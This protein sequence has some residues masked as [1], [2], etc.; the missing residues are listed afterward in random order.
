[1]LTLSH[2]NNPIIYNNLLYRDKK[3]QK[4]WMMFEIKMLMWQNEQLSQHFP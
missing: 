4:T 3:T 2:G 1:M